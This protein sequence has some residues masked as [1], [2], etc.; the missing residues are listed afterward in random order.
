MNAP[1]RF[2]PMPG[3]G[4]AL[5]QGAETPFVFNAWYAAAREEDVG[6]ALTKRQLLGK[7]LVLYRT[8]A[9]VPV[10]LADRCPHRSA[11][12]SMGHLRGDTI[13]CGYHGMTFDCAGACVR[14]PAQERVPPA[15]KVRAYPTV[16]RYGLVFVWMGDAQRADPALLPEIPQYGRPEWGLSR[17]YSFF[18]AN[19][20]NI[21]DNL[22]D[23]AHTSF[24]HSTTIGNAAAEEVPAQ[25]SVEGDT[26]TIG[27][28]IENAPPVPV[29]A[30]YT[31]WQ[32]MMDRW[33]FYHLKAPCISWV[34]FGAFA[35][36][37]ARSEEA[38]NAGPYRVL[39]YAFLAPETESTTHYFYFQLRNFAPQDAQVTQDFQVLYKRVFEED[40]ALLEAIQVIETEEPGVAPVRIAS[41]GGLTR[42]RRM[43]AAMREAERA[44]AARL[45]TH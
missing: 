16:Q 37:S 40:R 19:Y 34:D 38:K 7:R 4:T 39:S 36:G 29:I 35:P 22:V 8:E 30:R 32:G 5:V 28:W 6:R 9:G 13:E 14:V 11:P 20:E 15:A 2:Q 23:P 18:A 3:A 41:D 12:L 10:A 25:V 1:V 24:V 17:G 27:R 33:Q 31:G 44:G 26:L 42:L 43:V 21:T 45:T